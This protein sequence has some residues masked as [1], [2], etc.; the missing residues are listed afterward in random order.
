MPGKGTTVKVK[1][2]LTLAIMPALIVTAGGQR[3]AIPQ[4]SLLELVGLEGEEARKKVEMIQGAPVYRLRGSLLPLVD[5]NRALG[6]GD[7]ERSQ[8]AGCGANMLDFGQALLKHTQWLERLRQVLDEKTAMTV[9]EAGSHEVCALGKWLYGPCMQRYGALKETQLLESTHKHFH[10]LV[11]EIIKCKLNGE[12]DKAEAGYG[13]IGPVS[14]QVVELLNVVEKRAQDHNS[15]KIVVLRAEDRQF[16]LVVDEINNT[17]EI[18]VKP[19]SKHLKNIRIYAGATIMGDGKVALILDVLN[20]A[21]S[22]HVLAEGQPHTRPEREQMAIGSAEQKQRMVLFTGSGASRL[23]VPL[24]MLARLEN[25]PGVLVERS[26]KHWVT[27]Y[28]GQILQLIRIS[29]VLEDSGLM[30]TEEPELTLP[31]KGMLQVLV[32]ESQGKAF[33]LVVNQILDIVDSTLEPKSPPT[34]AGVLFSA[35]VAD[36]VTEILDVPAVLSTGEMN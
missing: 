36:R 29:H 8:S 20:L 1:I 19:L 22:A 3:F 16:G 30:S 21:Q 34:R 27:Q 35:V 14:R 25:I 10:G 28:R 33:G 4:V 23:A 17:E 15:V 31:T 11:R 6:Q 9:E 24:D 13:R 2:P 7:G 12:I 26:G 5:L 32:L 18:V